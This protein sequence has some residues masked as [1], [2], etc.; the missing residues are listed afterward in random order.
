MNLFKE[1]QIKLRKDFIQHYLGALSGGEKERAINSLAE[2][3]AGIKVRNL[4]VCPLGRDSVFSVPTCGEI[5]YEKN[6]ML[7]ARNKSM[8]ILYE[9]LALK[10]IFSA[11][12]RRQ[13]SGLKHL[14]I[15]FTNQ[16]LATFDEDDL[17]YHLRASIYGSP[18]IIS[19]SGIVEA[20]AKPKE[21]YLKERLGMDRQVLKKE[22]RG[23]FIDYDDKRL[24]EVIKGYILQAIFYR[25]SG[26]PF[27]ENKKCRLFNAH[28]QQELL[29]AQI[30]NKK[31]LCR[32][33]RKA[34]FSTNL[35]G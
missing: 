4:G 21:F 33:H 35:F 19:T 3:L 26:E 8:G 23:R 34:I 9:G 1:S 25:L 17:R 13:E 6:K 5:E 28:W 18:S 11:L 29:Q 16:L 15:I 12:I 2:E 27:C 14:H 10:A 31:E 32:R 24:T 7:N 20:P 30:K 22:F